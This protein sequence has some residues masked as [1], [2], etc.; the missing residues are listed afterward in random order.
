MS[1]TIEEIARHLARLG[2]T[3]ADLEAIT[4][5]LELHNERSARRIARLL[6]AAPDGSGLAPF[7]AVYGRPR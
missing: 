2:A 4:G 3:R 1:R 7:A 6:R 5:P